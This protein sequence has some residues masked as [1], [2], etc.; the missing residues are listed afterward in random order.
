LSC[1]VFDGTVRECGSN[2]GG[3]VDVGELGQFFCEVCEVEGGEVEA[4]TGLGAR[5]GGE[6]GEVDVL[7]VD[8]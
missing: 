7:P 2:D 6:T 4:R 5:L 8:G 1:S 3:E